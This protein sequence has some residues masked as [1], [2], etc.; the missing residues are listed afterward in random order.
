MLSEDQDASAHVDAGVEVIGIVDELSALR[1]AAPFTL[2]RV[3]GQ[4][5][6]AM[7]DGAE[8]HRRKLI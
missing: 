5:T 1:A 7:T 3:I 2:E 8:S 4:H 6:E